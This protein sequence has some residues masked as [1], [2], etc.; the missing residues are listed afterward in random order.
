MHAGPKSSAHERYLILGAGLAGLSCGHY[1]PGPSCILERENVAGGLARS[2]KRK[3]FTFDFTGHWLHMRDTGIRKWVE[4]LL[5]EELVTVNRTASIFSN[6]IHTPYPFQANT[7][8]LPTEV[9]SDCLLGFFRARELEAQ[10]KNKKVESF[11]DYIRQRM[12]DGIAEHFMIPYNTKI[13]TIPPSEMS[14]AWCERFVPIPQPEDVVHG[15]LSRRGASHGLGYNAT[16][17]YPKQ[18]GIGRMAQRLFETSKSDIH[19]GE[20]VV[21]VDWK[22]RTVTTVGAKT[23]CYE[24]LISTLPLKDLVLRM[25]NVPEA[26]KQAAQKLRATSVTYWDIGLQ[27]ESKKNAPHWT[28]F[29]EKKFPFYRVGSASAAVPQ[30]APLGHRSHYVEVSHPRGTPCPASGEDILRGLRDAGYLQEGEVPV[31]FERTTI[32]CAYVLMDHAY[33]E[34]RQTIL[35]FL[36]SVNIFSIGRYGAWTYDSMEGAMIQG[37]ETAMTLAALEKDAS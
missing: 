28:Y 25:Q 12:G 24:Y 33:G 17:E 18:G 6:G 15:A 35:D 2:F 32:D 4:S 36:K 26:V 34:A 5:G 27:G 29:P 9:V 21:E 22:S 13:F 37:R 19:L 3:D 1:L 7:Y 20:T 31:L 30:V 16:F 8:G 10:G 14:H 23:W 11:E